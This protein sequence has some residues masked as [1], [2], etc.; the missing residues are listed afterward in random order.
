VKPPFIRWFVAAL[1][2]V[3][4]GLLAAPGSVLAQD[5]SDE[6]E[7]PPGLYGEGGGGYGWGEDADA[8]PDPL[9]IVTHLTA[10][11][12]LRFIQDLDY[13]QERFAPAYL[14]LWGGIVLPGNDLRHSLGVLAAINLTG[15]GADIGVDGFSQFVVGPSYG[16]YIPLDSWLIFPKFTVPIAVT[17]DPSLGFELSVG[18]AYRFLAGFGLYAEIGAS[19]WIGGAGSIHPL[20]SGELG[21]I[22]DYEVLP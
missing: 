17:P 21:L 14:D 16:L 18:G 22:I 7:M 1:T 10:G 6:Y 11:T 13:A 4:G 15:D 19:I 20:A 2:L 8:P 5:E 9:R 12:S 3:V